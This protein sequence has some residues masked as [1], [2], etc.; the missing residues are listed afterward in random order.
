M[1]HIRRIALLGLLLL[2]LLAT[3]ACVALP[4]TGPVVP[5]ENE[6]RTRPQ[7]E[8]ERRAAP[9]QEGAPAQVVVTGFL[10]A[11][12]AY[13]VRIEVAR[14]FLASNARDAWIPSRKIV[15]YEGRGSVRGN[16]VVKVGI[17]GAHWVDDRG[18]WRGK[19]GSGEVE[20][21]FPMIKEDNEWRI[22]KAP[23]AFIVTDDWFQ[24]HYSPASI[25]YFDP[26]AGILVPEPVFVPDEQE[27]SALVQ[28]LLDGPGPQLDDVV[29]S[30]VPEGLKLG[31][32][33]PI[34]D[35]GVA[36]IALE[37]DSGPLPPDAAAL[38]IYQ[39]AWTL[40]QDPRITSFSITIGD[41]PVTL[42]GSTPLSIDLGS[43]YDPTDVAASSLLFRLRNGLLESGDADSMSPV[44]GPLGRNRY[45]VSDVAVSLTAALASTVSTDRTA[46]QLT[47]VN[48]DRHPFK[49]VLSGATRLLRPS[50][51][52]AD[53]LWLVDRRADGALVSMVDT[54]RD[55]TA[56]VAVDVPGIT[57]KRVKDFIVSRDG[58]RLVAVVKGKRGD[59]LRVS[60]LRYGSQGGLVGATPSRNL[61]WG[62][63]D[64]QR[65]RDIGW[66]S[67]TS[68]AVLNQLTPDYAQVVPVPVDGSTPSERRLAQQGR[69]SA[70]VSSPVPDETLYLVTV[71][72]LADPTGAEG[73][74]KP[75]PT[76]VTSIQYAG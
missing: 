7:A 35:E 69:A 36:T 39:F 22:A 66:R 34:S 59:T 21:K 29:T 64:A 1:A 75:L 58:T 74:A 45:G 42:D 8:V 15:T 57:G 12:T 50:W 41:Q 72:G 49:E 52:F 56:A 26:T 61:T 65:I 25:Y 5:A 37:G 55:E 20:L 16:D 23:N 62:T 17:Q 32:S 38:M 44:E 30:F 43:E 67:A 46:L 31:L 28:A 70:V 53:R 73:Q 10:Q 33:V 9:P 71:D 2:A 13:P 60:R 6:V 54:V 24:D 3:T 11:M 48:D 14:Q 19:R 51:D 27:A 18:T 68:V 4:D 47:S 40:R 63:D 76:G